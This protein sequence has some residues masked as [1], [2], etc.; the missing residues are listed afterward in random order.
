MRNQLSVPIE[1]EMAA[2]RPDSDVYD[3]G[4]LRVEHH[5][6][7]V[8][9]NSTPIHLSRKEFLIL[10][11]LARNAGRTVPM[12]V[13]WN[14]VWETESLNPVTLRVYI[15]HLRQKLIPFGICVKTLI[16]VGY[17]LCLP[18]RTAKNTFRSP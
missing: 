10:S 13:L 9:C 8:E 1:P 6:F 14:Y 3:D 11:R 12:D 16:S 7:Y 2:I 17:Y 15:S 5:S 18:D 4:Y